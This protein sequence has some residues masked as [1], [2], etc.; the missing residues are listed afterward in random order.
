MVEVSRRYRIKR[1]AHRA[2]DK[3]NP[4]PPKWASTNMKWPAA[5][6]NLSKPMS[7]RRRLFAVKVL[8]DKHFH[9]GNLKKMDNPDIDTRCQVCATVSKRLMGINTASASAPKDEG[10]LTQVGDCYLSH[11]GRCGEGG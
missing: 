2:D 8:Y 6:W 4:R 11:G 7:M 9:G 10:L 3:K 1:D 5:L